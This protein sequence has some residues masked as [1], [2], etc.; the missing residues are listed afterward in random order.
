MNCGAPITDCG[1]KQV[2]ATR[3]HRLLC[4]LHLDFSA[5][6]QSAIGDPQS[7]LGGRPM[8]TER[9][10]WWRAAAIAAVGGVV[11]TGGWLGLRG[12]GQPANAEAPAE[13]A[14]WTRSTAPTPTVTEVE[15]TPEPAPA[16]AAAPP[17]GQVIPAG[18]TLPPIP[19][20]VLPAVPAIPVPPPIVPVAALPVPPAPSGLEPASGP[21]I[22]DP[23]FTGGDKAALP[24]VPAVPAIPPAKLPDLPALPDAKPVAPGGPVPPATPVGVVPMPSAPVVPAVPA[25]PGVSAPALPPLPMSTAEPPKAAAPAILVAPMT[26]AAPAVPGPVGTAPVVPPPAVP[27]PG[28]VTLPQP[29]PTA[30]SVPPVNPADPVQP[31]LPA[32]PNSDLKP[33]NPGNTLN[34]TVAPAVPIVPG[35]TGHETHAIPV[36]RAKAPEA[37][38]NPTDKFVFPVPAVPSGA[39]PTVPHHRDDTMLNLTTTAAAAVLGGALLAA[40]KASAAPV[41]P[42]AP[43]IA[44]PGAIQLKGDEKSDVEKLKT[45]LAAANEKIKKLE[46]QV[47]ALTDLLTG[48]RDGI[49]IL[50]DPTNPGAV[51]EVKRLK[52][53]IASM[54]KEI[55]SLKTQTVLRPAAV[56]EVKPKGVV[57]IVNEYPVEISMVV[58]EKSYHIKPG[59]KLDVDV[60]AGDFTYQLLQS[61]AAATKSVI[62]DKETV[63]LRI[64]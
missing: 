58:N 32:K 3:G 51:E 15:R 39:N 50:A 21:R 24:A 46:D 48:K 57:R 54:Q 4:W 45:D 41:I 33:I 43:M 25:V 14:N 18:A 17:A 40:E 63:T 36:E 8:T 9:K 20:P 2:K 55:D 60:P 27:L 34:P 31:M 47:K 53:K 44:V 12:K 56:P 38:F 28:A 16:P 23:G 37:A 26:P 1:L 7:A 5:V 29:A 59:A 10:R 30:P 49:G 11:V 6:F 22:P 64:K 52:D 35:G 19:V 13:T 61:G 42:P 62:K